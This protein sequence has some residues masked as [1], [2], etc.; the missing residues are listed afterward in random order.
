MERFHYLTTYTTTDSSSLNILPE[1]SCMTRR[2]QGLCVFLQPK[3][4]FQAVGLHLVCFVGLCSWF[5][6]KN[7]AV[8]SQ[9]IQ[10]YKVLQEYKMCF[11]HF[12]KS[13]T[14]C[15]HFSSCWK[16]FFSHL[17]LFP[18]IV[19]NSEDCGI[20]RCRHKASQSQTRESSTE[21][22]S[23]YESSRLL[24][25]SVSA[26][27]DCTDSVGGYHYTALWWCRPS[28]FDKLYIVSIRWC[29]GH[30]HKPDWGILF[31]ILKIL[32]LEGAVAIFGH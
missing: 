18:S 15:N 26:I 14:C 7:S 30:S 12:C 9:S 5:G 28:C 19:Y 10:M 16:I 8:T 22:G 27:V 2:L 29:P 4:H 1:Y 6:Y 13:Y 20:R 21:K 25:W 11:L 31:F 32:I 24:A 17:V 23:Q 3:L